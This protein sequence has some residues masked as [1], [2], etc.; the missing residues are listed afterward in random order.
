MTEIW[1]LVDENKKK[2][3][4]LHKR[5][6]AEQIPKGLYHIVVAIWTKTPDGK[7]LLT[8]RSP[9]KQMPL[10]WECTM[11]SVLAGEESLSAAVRELA[12]ET[13][14]C[15]KESDLFHL[16]DTYYYNWIVESYLYLPKEKPTL[17]LQK[18]EVVDAKFVSIEEM[19]SLQEQMV[20]GV[21]KQFC[22]YREAIENH[23][24]V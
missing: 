7:L 13:G 4:I 8:R 9:N 1:E 20:S 21:W 10:L 5:E 16:G 2:T 12:E 24:S 14:I 22:K 17:S 11:G 23:I 18:E 19:A 3:G 6:N 15:A